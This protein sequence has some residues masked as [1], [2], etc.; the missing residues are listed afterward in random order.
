VTLH[1]HRAPRTDL[2]ADQLGDLLA[3]PLED[4]FATELVLVPARGVERWLSQRLSHRLGRRSDGSGAL[5][6][7]CAGVEFR[8]PRSLVAE[9]TGTVQD[10]PWAPDALAWPLLEV[11]DES[12]DGG[13][14]ARSPGTWATSTPVTRPSSGAGG[15]TPSP[16]ASPP[17]SPRT[18][19]SARSSSSTGSTAARPTGTAG[20]STTT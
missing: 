1:L 19:G 9:L 18:P 13:G 17:S 7:V 20:R 15:G 8:S 14:T 12:L 2:L 6:G 16:A 10:D 4:P 11:I 3:R 5:D